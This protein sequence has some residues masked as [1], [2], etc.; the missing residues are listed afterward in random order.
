M[1]RGKAGQGARPEKGAG[2]AVGEAGKGV[3]TAGE[4]VNKPQTWPNNLKQR[5]TTLNKYKIKCKMINTGRII[6]II[7]I[8][9]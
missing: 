7:I 6:I 9:I 8:I 4:Q 1:E 3:G 2:T 5:Y